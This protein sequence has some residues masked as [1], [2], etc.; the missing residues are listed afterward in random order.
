[1]RI[2]LAFFVIGNMTPDNVYY[3]RRENILGK[4]E[5]LKQKTV[6]ERKQYNSKMTIGVE[7]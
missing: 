4:R 6:L 5:E 7:N 2:D 3:S 1:V